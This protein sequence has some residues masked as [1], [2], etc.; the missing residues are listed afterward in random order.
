MTPAQIVSLARDFTSKTTSNVTAAQAYLA[1][2]M[3]YKRMHSLF[4]SVD[5][6]YWW[7]RYSF[8]IVANQFEYTINDIDDVTPDW[9]QFKIERIWVKYASTDTLF[10]P[11]RREQRDNLSEMYDYYAANQPSSDPFYIVTDKSWMLFPTPTASVTAWWILETIRKPYT[12][13][14]S[15]AESDIIIDPYY[16]EYMA[17]WMM[18]Y[19]YEFCK[20]I[21]LAANARN[22]FEQDLQTIKEDIAMRTTTP[23]YWYNVDLDSLQ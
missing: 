8:N 14:S 13:T 6:N 18:E 19:F 7:Q 10:T 20:E 2:N 3:V 5:K 23:V 12:L 22:M 9:G 17:K 11:I 21:E 16:H 1:L 4:T 15:M